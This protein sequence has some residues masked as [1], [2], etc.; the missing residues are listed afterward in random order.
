MRKSRLFIPEK[1]GSLVGVRQPK[2]FVLSISTFLLLLLFPSAI[3]SQSKFEFGLSLGPT[4]GFPLY[5]DDGTAPDGVVDAIKD[6]ETWAPGGSVTLLV[7]MHLSEKLGVRTGF[8]LVATGHGTKESDVN[9][10]TP[11]PDAPESV[12][13]IYRKNYLELPLQV[14][15]K[16]GKGDAPDFFYL[17]G[18][19]SLWVN[20]SNKTVQVA[21]F[22]DGKKE[23]TSSDD[24]T[25]DFRK[26][27]ILL[28]LGFG[29]EQELSKRMRLAIE[30]QAKMTLLTLW[31][32]HVPLNRKLLTV[33]LSFSVFFK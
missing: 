27:N 29:Y 24:T 2:H 19:A 7:K 14:D 16:L 8:G 33:G 10:P 23:R 22:A 25:S 13:F 31:E 5:V 21:T 17:S 11:E 1:M 9:F 26:S 28:Q 3:F 15:F 30:P 20:I 32:E 4:L 12:K 6:A 18:G